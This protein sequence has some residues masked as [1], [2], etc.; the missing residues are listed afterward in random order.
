MN[1]VGSTL[2]EDLIGEWWKEVDEAVTTDVGVLVAY[3]T[4]ICLCRSTALAERLVTWIWNG[5][6][7]RTSVN[8]W[9]ANVIWPVLSNILGS[10]A[11]IPNAVVV[12]KTQCSL[13]G[14]STFCR[15]IRIGCEMASSSLNSLR[16]GAMTC[17]GLDWVFWSRCVAERIVTGWRCHGTT[18]RSTEK[19]SRKKRSIIHVPT[20]ISTERKWTIPSHTR[21]QM[22]LRQT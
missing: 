5:C 21:T 1:A 16:G 9:A 20:S 12:T 18:L 15:A 14:L 22:S 19:I 4:T 10:M 3:T 17:D 6:D 8:P 2:L 13:C 7:G 11:L